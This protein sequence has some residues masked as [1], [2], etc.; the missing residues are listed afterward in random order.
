MT[1]ILKYR[2]YIAKIEYSSEDKLLYGKIEG[3]QDLISFE[4]E[5]ASD[6]ELEFHNAVDDYLEFCEANKKIPDKPYKGSFNVRIAPELHKRIAYLAIEKN[7]SLNELVE[8]SIKQYLLNNTTS[9][10]FD[11]L[12]SL[13]NNSKGSISFQQPYGFW[14]T[15]KTYTN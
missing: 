4:A 9:M 15:A 13:Q 1:N 8:Q 6:I 7:I 3:I 14:Q 11:T 10:L 5:N 12:K 2:G